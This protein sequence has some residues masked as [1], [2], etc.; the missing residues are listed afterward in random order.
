MVLSV[1]ETT[2]AGMCLGMPTL[3]RVLFRMIRRVFVSTQ[4]QEY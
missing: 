1:D 3:S 2:I 4:A